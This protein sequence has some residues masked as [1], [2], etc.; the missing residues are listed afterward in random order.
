VAI[1]LH[2]QRSAS[3]EALI[4]IN[5]LQAFGDVPRDDDVLESLKTNGRIIYQS[6]LQKKLATAAQARRFGE[7]A[8][9]AKHLEEAAND[10]EDRTG[11]RNVRQSFEARSRKQRWSWGIGG[12]VVMGVIVLA[13]V[14]DNRSAVSPTYRAPTAPS[15]S[16]EQTSVTIPAPG[17]GGLSGSELRWCLLE[18]D[19][20]KRIRQIAVESPTARVADAWNARHT[21]WKGR[22][23]DKK[24]YK[25]DN[26]IAE[27]IVQASAATLQS[28]ATVI[29]SSWS[30]PETPPGATP[31]LVPG[32]RR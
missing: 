9:L 8:K 5:T 23:A 2:N 31:N 7:S 4:L 15:A 22:C 3:D 24:Y 6:I 18:I 27:R 1:E 10:D 29:Y 25:S 20:L 26:D 30:Q 19:R 14:G 28:E 11:W 21:D 16:Y 17:N 32:T 13:S 12:A